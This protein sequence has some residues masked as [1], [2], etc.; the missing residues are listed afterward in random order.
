MKKE[1]PLGCGPAVPLER[2][3]EVLLDDALPEVHVVER[4]LRHDALLLAMSAAAKADAA[5]SAARRQAAV[6]MEVL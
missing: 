6:E 1:P 5:E 4:E 3:V 2:L